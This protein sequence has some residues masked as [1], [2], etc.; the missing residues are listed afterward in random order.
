MR[1]SPSDDGRR[2]GLRAMS[3]KITGLALLLAGGGFLIA[4]RAVDVPAPP[5]SEPAEP[6]L[7]VPVAAHVLDSAPPVPAHAD[8]VLVD[9]LPTAPLPAGVRP[10]PTT[11]GEARRN[12]AS[13]SKTSA[14]D[15]RG[16]APSV[17]ELELVQR[18][19]ATLAS[20]PGRALAIADEHARVFPSGEFLQE[21][22][23]VAIDALVRLG[24]K[25]EAQRRARALVERFPETPY[26]VRVEMAVGKPAAAAPKSAPP[27]VDD[28]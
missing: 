24:R 10:A 19:E 1:R 17:R 20:D 27:A 18:A 28:R 2:A 13:V 9:Q 15:G 4:T 16:S 5:P 22:E 25:E 14:A 7:V 26:A 21:R 23:A 3:Y 8:T 6:R 12:A 11:G